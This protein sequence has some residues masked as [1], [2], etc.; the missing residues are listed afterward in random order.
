MSAHGALEAAIPPWTTI[1]PG[2]PEGAPSKLGRAVRLLAAFRPDDD[3]V[4]LAELARR[5]G[6]P[7]PTAHR[8]LGELAEWELVERTATGHRLGVR[9]FELGA[10]APLQRRLR[11]TAE[12]FLADLLETTRST[13]HLAVLDGAEV[14]YVDKLSSRHGPV[15]AS[16]LGG[17]MP[18]HC[19]GVG[20][21][22][23]AHSSSSALSQMF[24]CG[25]RR[26][27]PRTLVAPGLVLREL[28]TVRRRGIAEEHEESTR[29]IACVAAPVIG[30]DRQA[31][32][33]VS[34]TGWATRLDTQR[35]APAVL[36][37]ARGIAEALDAE[38]TR[39]RE[40]EHR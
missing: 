7:K 36:A 22:L 5:T 37:A 34:V 8:I 6:I 32:A 30:E 25:L 18:A 19:T 3:E 13:V 24:R 27:T 15:L 35:M 20:K 10:L 12:P 29:G 31:V 14:V 28:S 23:L 17:R 33:A 11:E 16:R 21:A 40:A 4:G 26:R 9:L 38:R 1:S 39:S 2:R